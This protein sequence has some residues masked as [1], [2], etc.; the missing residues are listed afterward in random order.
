MRLFKEGID[1]CNELDTLLEAAKESLIDELDESTISLLNKFD[2]F[3]GDLAQDYYMSEKY[4]NLTFIV[5]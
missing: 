4:N 2:R 1:Y 3:D 5:N